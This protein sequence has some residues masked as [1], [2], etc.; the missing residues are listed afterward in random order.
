MRKTVIVVPAMAGLTACEDKIRNDS[1]YGGPTCPFAHLTF[2]DDGK[3]YIRT[4]DKGL[5]TG[6]HFKSGKDIV[7]QSGKIEVVFRKDGDKLVTGSGLARAECSFVPVKGARAPASGNQAGII[8]LILFVA[9]WVPLFWSGRRGFERTN[10]AG[11]QEFESFGHMVG[12]RL[13]EKVATFAGVVMV[14]AGVAV[15]VVNWT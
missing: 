10:S 13:L 7:V 15:M 9:G 4:R 3:V 5:I 11:V 12:A 6:G 8:G 1:M 14:L 2:Y